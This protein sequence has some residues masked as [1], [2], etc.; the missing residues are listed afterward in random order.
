MRNAFLLAMIIFLEGCAA[1]PISMP[2]LFTSTPAPAEMALPKP[3]ENGDIITPEKPSFDKND[4]I[5]GSIQPIPRNGIIINKPRIMSGDDW[6]VFKPILENA[7]SANTDEEFSWN[8]PKT[9]SHGAIS[10]IRSKTLTCPLFVASIVKN[11][12]DHWFEG[13]ICTTKSKTIEIK[14]IREWVSK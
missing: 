12:K 6:L 14:N 11:N 2:S 3:V 4:E 9:L 5:T 1:Y 10:I 8:N 7:V 13:N